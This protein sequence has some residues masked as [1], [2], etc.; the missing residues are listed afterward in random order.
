MT[1]LIG[2]VGHYNESEEEFATYSDR[3]DLFFQANDIADVKKVASFLSMVGPKLFKLISDL[4]SPKSPGKCSYTDII[5]KVKAHYKPQTN[6]IFERYKFYKRVQAQTETVSDFVAALKSL[7][8]TCSF[9]DK[10]EEQLRDRFV[11]GIH[12]EHT[13]RTLLATAGLTC[14]DAFNIALSKE[15]ASKESKAIASSNSNAPNSTGTHAV[16]D[17]KKF[18]SSQRSF[19]TKNSHFSKPKNS[20]FSP[21][22]S[23]GSSSKPKSKKNIKCYSCHGSHLRSD[24]PQR[25]ATCR[26]CSKQGHVENACLSRKRDSNANSSPKNSRSSSANFNESYDNFIHYSSSPQPIH[27]DI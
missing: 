14:A 5:D 7:A 23:N 12:D 11:V 4:V 6:V 19:S 25:D 3:V 27:I 22:H 9:G 21:K 20:N 16:S 18:H 13:Q 8:K 15:A 26:Y 10:L 2:H 1:S 17:K 24:C